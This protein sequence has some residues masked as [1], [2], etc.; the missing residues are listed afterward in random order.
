VANIA[1]LY[2]VACICTAYAWTFTREGHAFSRCLYLRIPWRKELRRR[3]HFLLLLSSGREADMPL[4]SA[5]HHFAAC[6]T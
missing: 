1:F 2:A 3:L 5:P 4:F 6:K